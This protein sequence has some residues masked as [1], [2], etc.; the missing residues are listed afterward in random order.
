MTLRVAVDAQISPDVA[1]GTETALLT[2][3]SALRGHGDE[4]RFF[5]LAMK[6][7]V[8]KLRP[9]LGPHQEPVIWP[10]TY[11]WYQPHLDYQ[12]PMTP[13]WRRMQKLSGPLAPWVR[14]VH[15][16]YSRGEYAMGPRARSVAGRL[17]LPAP[18]ATRAYRFYRALATARTRHAEQTSHEGLLRQRDVHVVHFP[19]PLHF[20]T[21]LPFVYEPWG[22]PHTHFP[23]LY[24][25]GEAEWMD[26]MFRH[27]CSHAAVIVVATRWVKDDIVAKYRIAPEKIAVI[28]RRP[29]FSASP[30][31]QVDLDA[32]Y[33]LPRQFAF[34]PAMTLPT[35]NHVRLIQA[36][37]A[38][39]DLHGISLPVICT[40]RHKTAQWPAI[41]GELDRLGMRG[42][43]RFL[44]P[45]PYAHVCALFQRARFLIFP[46]LFEGLGLPI[47][48]AFHYGLP[49][50]AASSACVPEVV[51]DAG[52]LFNGHDV[53]DMAAALRVAATDDVTLRLLAEKGR[54]RLNERYPDRARLAE[55]FITCYQ[56]ASGMTMKSLPRQQFLEMTS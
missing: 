37:C 2:L 55:M 47:V 49:V 21:S 33:R 45:I 13:R 39:R 5:V 25:H 34:F 23:D 19:Y 11:R 30:P 4:A 29:E 42:L 41:E 16:A 27:G 6:Q 24:P 35:K 7:F 52:F 54:R 38:L 50:V 32:L 43:V 17:R 51:G 26:K 46:S 10:S 36:V 28:P 48:E 12:H 14:S 44:G 20:S 31:A 40:G 53:D 8:D 1:G 56:K 22:L 9:Y 3:L 18:V 15:A